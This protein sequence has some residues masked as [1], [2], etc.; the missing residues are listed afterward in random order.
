[1]DIGIGLDA[2]LGLSEQELKTLVREAAQLG[3]TSAWT[4]ASGVGRD[5][6]HTCAGWHAASAEVTP[7]GIT[8]GISVVPAPVWTAPTLASQAGTVGELTGGR[9]ILGIGTGG[10]YSAEFRRSFGLPAWPPVAMMRDY[11]TTI[12]RLLAGDTLAYDGPVVK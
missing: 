2:R 6:F 7:G 3:Y 1:M 11:V 12:R 5:A 10:I 8:T 9:F 4:P